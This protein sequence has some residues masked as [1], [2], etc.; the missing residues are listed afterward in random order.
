MPPF[1][2]LLVLIAAADQA[3]RD[4]LQFALRLEGFGVRTHS[5]AEE[6]LMDTALERAA[7]V[8]LDDHRPYLDGFEVLT[9]LRARAIEVPVILLAGYVP[10]R[11]RVRAAAAGFHAV[12][13]KPLLNNVLLDALQ[14]ITEPGRGDRDDVSGRRTQVPPDPPQP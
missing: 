11:L 3:V 1:R 13:E 4:S 8:I 12:L 5:V 9:R 10:V 6:L 2:P 14:T 7:C